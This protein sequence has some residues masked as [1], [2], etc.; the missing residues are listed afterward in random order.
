MSDRETIRVFRSADLPMIDRGSGIRSFPLVSRET[1][2][3]ALLSGMT[4]IPPGSSIP[5]HTHSSDES[6]MIL[7]GD[8]VCEVAGQR[9][10]LG[11]FDT[12]YISAGIVHR[13]LNVGARDLR[14]LWIYDQLDTTRTFV[15]TGE[16]A[17]HLASYRAPRSR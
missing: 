11:R 3:R 6:V 5:T 16:T 14:I 8:G 10:H 13:F 12:T 9:H 17:G 7:E 2:S 15:E 1:G 4:L